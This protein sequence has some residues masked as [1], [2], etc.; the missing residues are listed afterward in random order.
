MIG[1]ALFDRREDLLH[2]RGQKNPR[3]FPRAVFAWDILVLFF[4]MIGDPISR[5]M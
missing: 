3:P 1:A 5:S 2:H 4:R